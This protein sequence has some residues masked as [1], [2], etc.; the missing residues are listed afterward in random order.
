MSACS[1][2]S[3]QNVPITCQRRV[4]S[5]L[6]TGNKPARRWR[7][8]PH[9][10]PGQDSS[11]GFFTKQRQ[12]LGSNEGCSF[13]RCSLK[14]RREKTKKL[15]VPVR[16]FSPVWKVWVRSGGMEGGETY[17]KVAH[18]PYLPYWTTACSWRF[19]P[20]LFRRPFLTTL[21]LNTRAVPFSVLIWIIKL[22]LYGICLL[23]GLKPTKE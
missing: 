7:V 14:H 6:S 22:R 8:S 20:N 19:R 15:G 13:I 16:N 18:P 17:R 1:L 23:P 9:H 11:H 21:T 2:T 12:C 10:G 4:F 5:L 3:G